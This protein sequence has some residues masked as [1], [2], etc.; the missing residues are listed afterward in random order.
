MNS[1]VSSLAFACLLLSLA[2]VSAQ[3]VYSAG[4]TPGT[5][6]CNT[7]PL[8]PTT[9]NS[10]WSNQKYQTIVPKTA[11]PSAG[12]VLC[13]LGFAS[14]ATG[15]NRVLSCVAGTRSRVGKRASEIGRALQAKSTPGMQARTG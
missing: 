9:A 15:T 2:P 8:G 1:K 12:G 3:Y 13:S 10:T 14:C 11:L 4:N 5:G 6:A 7:I